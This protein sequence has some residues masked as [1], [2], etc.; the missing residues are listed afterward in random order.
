M[1][2]LEGPAKNER[3]SGYADLAGRVLLSLI[4]LVSGV[5]KVLNWSMFEGMMREHGMP[6]VPLFLTLAILFELGAG[7][8]LLLGNQTRRAA[9]ALVVFLIPTTLVFH[10]FWDHAGTAQQDQLQHFL[11]NVAILGGLMKY[12]AAGAGA[13]SL[14]ARRSRFGGLGR[15]FGLRG[16]GIL[17][18]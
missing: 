8:C 18:R 3:S 16:G 4:F 1:I 10:N 12:V 9:L 7:T 14:D 13:F 15:W 17:G 11:K 2:R 5:M 6:A